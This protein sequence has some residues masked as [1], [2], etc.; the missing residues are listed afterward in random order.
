VEAGATCLCKNIGNPCAS[1][2]FDH[3]FHPYRSGLF[4]HQ[5]DASD[6]N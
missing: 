5:S 1:P 4:S 2:G 3:S 6:D